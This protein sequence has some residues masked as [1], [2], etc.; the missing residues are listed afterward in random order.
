MD[1]A[2]VAK[3]VAKNNGES[4][5]T[6]LGGWYQQLTDD[7]RTLAQYLSICRDFLLNFARVFGIDF[8]LMSKF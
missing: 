8:L 7:V 4:H 3:A 2:E 1:N 6:V 5:F